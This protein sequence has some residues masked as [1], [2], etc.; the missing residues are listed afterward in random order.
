[1]K[2][3]DGVAG[4]FARGDALKEDT[5]KGR[6]RDEH[7][8][9]DSA[10]DGV[11]FPLI[12]DTIRDIGVVVIGQSEN[13]FAGKDAI[14][15]P[16]LEL[17]QQVRCG[18]AKQVGEG[19]AAGSR[20]GLGI[21]G[22]REQFVTGASVAEDEG[23]FADDRLRFLVAAG[24]ADGVPGRRFRGLAPALEALVETA[25]DGEAVLV[26]GAGKEI[27]HRSRRFFEILGEAARDE[28][29]DGGE[30]GGE[31]EIYSPPGLSR[32]GLGD[33]VP[34]HQALLSV[35][36]IRG[37]GAQSRC[38]IPSFHGR[39]ALESRGEFQANEA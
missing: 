7:I 29:S 39:N 17:G 28:S 23:K 11:A 37:E 19:G 10:V 9:H 2:G 38:E 24:F 5:G 16:F 32:N 22:D 18:V 1:M 14:I 13:G 34:N 35:C 6:S 27:V 26:V 31:G 20:I 30:L 15:G 36:G 8:D 4:N 12:E 33:S 21:R 25:E 3:A